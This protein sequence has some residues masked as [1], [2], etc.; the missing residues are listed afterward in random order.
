VASLAFLIQMRL[1]GAAIKPAIGNKFG[2]H[3]DI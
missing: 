1:A 3:I 2:I